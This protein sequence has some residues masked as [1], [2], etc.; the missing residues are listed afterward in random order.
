MNPGLL[1][2]IDIKRQ[3]LKEL[4]DYFM[5][6]DFRSLGH[7]NY[8]NPKKVL[9][10]NIKVCK[11]DYSGKSG[12]EP[13][14]KKWDTLWDKHIEERCPNLFWRCCEDGLRFV[15]DKKTR[16]YSW[17]EG[18]PEIEKC[19]YTLWQDGRS[20]GWLI[21][22]KFDD[23]Q[24]TQEVFSDILIFIDEEYV[25]ECKQHPD[26]QNCDNDRCVLAMGDYELGLL[27][28]DIEE[29]ISNLTKLKLFCKSLDKF[30]AT[31]EWNCQCN[32]CRAEQE[33]E[34]ESGNF[35]SLDDDTLEELLEKELPRSIKTKI[36]KYLKTR[37]QEGSFV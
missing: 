31:K 29:H 24:Y 22:E 25:Y 4:C 32:W 10:W 8:G 17:H 15:G 6:R 13:I 23:K 33:Q 18:I 34:W 3:Q 37:Q 30:D 35:D 1:L 36:K 9:C 7:D 27:L 20:G 14:N 26:C 16:E 28:L 19:D 11:S 21:L 12:P 5:A 2:N